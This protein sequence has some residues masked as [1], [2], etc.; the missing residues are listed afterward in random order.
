[1]ARKQYFSP[2]SFPRLV[3]AISTTLPFFYRSYAHAAPT[4]GSVPSSI[5]WHNCTAADPPLLD[6]DELQV[7]LDWGDPRG[8]KI[9]LGMVRAKAA[10]ASKRLGNLIFNPGGPGSAVS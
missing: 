10:D 9:T 1:M 5:K 7:P 3:L 8:K 2:T 6:C 4:A